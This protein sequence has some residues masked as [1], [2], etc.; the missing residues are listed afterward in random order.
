MHVLDLDHPSVIQRS[1]SFLHINPLVH[2]FAA[3]VVL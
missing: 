1:L 3:E 2:P